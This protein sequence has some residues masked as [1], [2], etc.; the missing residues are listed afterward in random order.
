MLEYRNI[1]ADEGNS[2]QTTWITTYG[3]GFQEAQCKAEEINKSLAL[4]PTWQHTTSRVVKVVPRRAPNL[5]DLLFK[6][7]ALALDTARSGTV[8]CTDSSVVKRGAKCEC[9]KLVSQLD[10]NFPSCLGS[11]KEAA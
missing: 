1:E 3:E 10:T 7:K 9:C 2:C 5:K 8:P 4:S 11:P 6:R